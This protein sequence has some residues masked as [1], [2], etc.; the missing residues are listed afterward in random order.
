MPR[1]L[2]GFVNQLRNHRPP[3]TLVSLSLILALVA[4]GG[5]YSG[6]K[7]TSMPTPTPMPVTTPTPALSAIT[8]QPTSS[9]A[10]AVAATVQV[11]ANGAYPDS[12][13]HIT[14]QDVTKSATWS[15]SNPA[16]ATVAMG[17]VTGQG[18]GS[19]TISAS[20]DGKNSS[21]LVV[22]GQTASL[23]LS[24]QG[25]GALSLAAPDRQFQITASYPDGSVLDLTVYATWSSSDSGVLKFLNDYDYPG[26]AHLVAPG[27]A[28]IT[29]MQDTGDTIV[30][31]ISVGP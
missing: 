15:T 19:A 31:P 1:H 12:A 21:T 9:P 29:A 13:T 26:A 22:V 3:L 18:I 14:Y 8:L 17:L 11:G 28:T 20:L 10:I 25:S 5:G 23:A 24:V 6:T 7:S 4:C 2:R 16:V 27:T 30:L